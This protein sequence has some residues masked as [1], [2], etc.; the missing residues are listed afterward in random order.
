MA[1]ET[2]PKVIDAPKW[3]WAVLLGLCFILAIGG[4]IG[5]YLSSRGT[6]DLANTP[7]LIAPHR[8]GDKT[9][10]KTED[11]VTKGEKFLVFAFLGILLLAIGFIPRLPGAKFLGGAGALLLLLG[12]ITAAVFWTWPDL[13]KDGTRSPQ[14][15]VTSPAAPLPQLPAGAKL[16]TALAPNQI[17]YLAQERADLTPPE[18]WWKKQDGQIG[19]ENAWPS[20]SKYRWLR[21]PL[22]GPIEIWAVNPK[23]QSI[24][25]SFE[26][27][28]VAKQQSARAS[29]DCALDERFGPK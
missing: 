13:G 10:A 11:K 27:P 1:G 20:G 18:C 7:Q 9:A 22:D 25:H 26:R 14:G 6:E 29:A 3:A 15:R 5:S 19:R 23:G 8:Q 12:L 28:D 24:S 17:V 2:A 21:N 16:V 4:V